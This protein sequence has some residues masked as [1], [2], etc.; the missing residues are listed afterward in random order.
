MERRYNLSTSH[1]SSL[2][3]IGQAA[4]LI[5]IMPV[6]YLGG[7]PSSSRPRWIGCGLLTLG[8]S[9]FIMT[10]PH[11]LLGEY[12]Y[13]DTAHMHN[14]TI[15]MNLCSENITLEDRD[16]ACNIEKKTTKDSEVAYIIMVI[17]I[18]I[19]G[20]AYSTL[21]TLGSSYVDDHAKHVSSALYLGIMSTMWGVGA[22]ATSILAAGCLLLYVD[23]N[24]VDVSS[25]K[26]DN[27]DPKWIGAWW[28]GKL[29]LAVI[30]VLIAIPY[31]LVQKES[32][33]VRKGHSHRNEQTKMDEAEGRHEE[34]TMGLL[35][36]LKGILLL[37][38]R[39]LIN[40]RY[41]TLV[42]GYGFDLGAT[43]GM[44]P[45][46]PKYFEV[47]FG[48]TPSVANLYTGFFFSIQ[49]ALSSLIGGIIIKKFKLQEIGMSKF[50]VIALALGT[51]STVFIYPF[52]C[53]GIEISGV[54]EDGIAKIQHCNQNCSCSVDL[55]D[56]V[57]GS[58]GKTYT[59]SCHAG[60]NQLGENDTYT[61]CGC[62]QAQVNG[63]DTLTMASSGMCNHIETCSLFYPLL[64]ALAFHVFVNTLSE[65]PCLMLTMRSGPPNHKSFGLGLR[66]VINRCLGFIPAPMIYGMAIDKSCSVWRTFCEG[67]AKGECLIYDNQTFRRNFVVVTLGLKF[68]AFLLYLCNHIL[69][70]RRGNQSGADNSEKTFKYK[71]VNPNSDPLDSPSAML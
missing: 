39:Y 56:P 57:C 32:P 42:L 50:L 41:M 49:I 37:L 38:W 20:S 2:I 34:S 9:T 11:F 16:S 10:L 70:K 51:L 13:S 45:F 68:A 31:F 63:T 25:L 15:E 43:I 29:C 26:I 17:G 7:R 66:I 1:L 59:S 14:D 60:C 52:H 6:S 55:F 71:E 65:T 12:R 53:G 58:D 4:V 54:S 44:W 67:S 33:R 5:A 47:L 61:E 62:M 35:N 48:L 64:I 30:C 21:Y 22:L 23:F 8:L 46:I 27:S 28:L 24:R 69:W 40:P 3:S 18:V 19:M 36:K